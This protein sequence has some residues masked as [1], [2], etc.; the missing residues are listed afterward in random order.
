M[1]TKQSNIQWLDT[2]RALATVGVIIIHVSSPLVNMTY[3][4]NMVY[5]WIGNLV[6]SSVRFAVPVFLMLSGA[7]LLGKEYKLSEFYQRRFAR[8]L[9]PFLF[10][11]LVYCVYRWAMLKTWQQP[12]EPL[13]ILSWAGKLFLKEGVSK[14]FW[15]IYMILF[16]YLFVPFL[17]KGLRKLSLPIISSLLL[18]WIVLCFAFKSVPLNMYNWANGYGSKF[19]GYFLYTGYLILGYYLSKLPSSTSKFRFGAGAIFTGSIL[20]SAISTYIFSQHAGHLDL[21][22][23]GYL[24]VN[25][26]IQSSALFVWIKDLTIKDTPTSI[27]HSQI[28]NYSYGIYLVHIIIIGILF[29]N[30]I[31]WSFTHP[32]LSLPLLTIGVLVCSF[33]IIFVLRKIPFGKYISG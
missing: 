5:W 14:H 24:S 18:L 1:P 11:L 21:T 8:V 7:T 17:G 6:D 20:V 13:S 26:I 28:S 12:Q 23:Y 22:M 25:T 30:G 3:D 27:I 32:L 29:R 33:L 10:W 15:Y 16:I 9:L 19:G 4:D 2:L 31:Y